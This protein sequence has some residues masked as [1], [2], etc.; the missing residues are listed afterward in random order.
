[1]SVE[2]A[3]ESLF[4]GVGVSRGRRVAVGATTAGGLGR[5]VFVLP[6]GSGWEAAGEVW[7]PPKV[8]M[9]TRSAHDTHELLRSVIIKAT[10][11]LRRNIL[12]L[13]WNSCMEMIKR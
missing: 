1:V 11:S 8:M 3:Q 9:T 6:E 7:Q 4:P 5:G 2:T 13:T 12:T 10:S